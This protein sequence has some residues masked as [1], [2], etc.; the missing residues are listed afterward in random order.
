MSPKKTDLNIIFHP[1]DRRHRDLDNM[2]A[3]IKSGL[4]GVAD[5]WGVNDREFKISLSVGNVIK[6]GVVKIA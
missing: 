4:D 3:S 1:P 2:L 6:L 5:A